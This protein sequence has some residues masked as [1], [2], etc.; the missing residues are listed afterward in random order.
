MYRF[1]ISFVAAALFFAGPSQVVFSQ[2]TR[3]TAETQESGTVR[4]IQSGMI[5][6]KSEDGRVVT[7]KIQDKDDRAISISGIPTRMPAKISVSG[8]LPTSLLEK[9]M[10]VAFSGN[11]SKN[12]KPEG[13]IGQL[14]VLAEMT[15]DL[16]YDFVESSEPDTA[17]KFEVVGRVSERKKQK[18]QLQVPKTKWTKRERI[19]FKL[20]TD[21]TMQFSGNDLNRVVPGDEVSRMLILE[22][23][24]GDRVVKEIDIR[25]TA[26]RD[27]VTTAFHDKLE[28]EFSHLSNEPGEPRE[29]RS[30]NYVI[31]TDLSERSAQILLAKLETMHDLIGD[32]YGKRPRIPIECYVISDINLWKDQQLHPAGV[33]KILEPAGITMTARHVASGQ[34]KAVVYSCENHNVVQHEAVHAF[35]AQAFGSPGPVWYS[36]GMAEMGQYWKPDELSVNIDPVVIDYLTNATPKKMRD[37]VAAG[38]ITG[39]SW[40]AYAWRWALCHLLASNPNYARRFKKLG[41]SIMAGGDDSFDKAFGKVADKISF[42]YDQFV[43]NFGNGYRVD[44]CAWDWSVAASNLNSNGRTKTEIKAQAGWQPT[45]LEARAGVSY[46]YAAKGTWK[47]AAAEEPFSAN[48]HIEG[49]GKLVGVILHDFQ[50]E[51]PFE[52]GTRGSFVAPV[53]GQLYLRCQDSWT[54]L[55]DNEGE[56]TVYLRR[57]PKDAAKDESNLR[58]ASNRGPVSHSFSKSTG[59]PIISMTLSLAAGEISPSVSCHTFKVACRIRAGNP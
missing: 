10:I 41:L 45:K 4:D 47:T 21:S 55:A 54:E 23:S 9:G 30:A 27:Q 1:S 25:L 32:Y 43:Q 26:D 50:L 17:G 16:K 39:D 8:T 49:R 18:L 40:R 5:S 29:L 56:M 33:A 15:A 44:L 48:G 31:Y 42:E 7:C 12:G 22:L 34:A 20:A 2:L 13:E 28:Q 19:T 38:Q 37:I 59:S 53:T 35:C 52:L 14:K 58:L 6:I 3:A 57:T 46:D 24:N 51:G 36:E 11:A